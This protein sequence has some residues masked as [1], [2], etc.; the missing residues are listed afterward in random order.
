MSAVSNAAAGRP[1]RTMRSIVGYLGWEVPSI[2]ALMVAPFMA[3]CASLHAQQAQR[4]AA[5]DLRQ[6]AVAPAE[7]RVS[8]DHRAERLGRVVAAE[9]R[10]VLDEVVGRDSVLPRAR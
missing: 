2:S 10:A 6:H 9:Q 1:T 3:R 8:L 4:V 7:A 5:E